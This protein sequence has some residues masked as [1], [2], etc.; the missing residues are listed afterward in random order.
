MEKKTVLSLFFIFVST[1]VLLFG[2]YSL[3]KSGFS[4]GSFENGI[5]DWLLPDDPFTAQSFLGSVAEVIC[6]ILAIAIT[7]VAIIVQLAANRYTSKIIDLFINNAVNVIILSSFVV[8]SVYGL[9]VTNS[10]EVTANGLPGENFFPR[11]GISAYL[12]LTSISFFVLVPYFF[13]VF[14][15]LKPQ[16]IINRIKRQADGFLKE[17]VIK[18]RKLGTEKSND[19]LQDN[20]NTLQDNVIANI[21]QLSEMAMSSLTQADRSLGVDC[22]K[23]MQEILTGESDHTEG[24]DLKEGYLDRKKQF[25][26][27]W[28]EVQRK[29]FGEFDQETINEL[30]LLRYWVE[31][32]IAQEFLAILIHSLNKERKLV[33]TI[34]ISTREIGEKALRLRSGSD[35]AVLHLTINSFNTYLKHGIDKDDILS[36]IDIL[37]QY[38]FFAEKILQESE[39]PNIVIVIANRFKDYGRIAFVE[40]MAPVLETIAFDLRSLNEV[41]FKCYR[42]KNEADEYKNIIRKLLDIFLAVDD[43]PERSQDEETLVGV[44]KSQAILASFYMLR[45]HDTFCSELLTKIRNDMKEEPLDRLRSIKKEILACET[46]MQ[47][48]IDENRPNREYITLNRKDALIEFFEQLGIDP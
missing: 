24:H 29:H 5:W 21:E 12:V 10:I 35:D 4:S 13:Y 46:E 41:A 33:N 26:K 20:V 40:H 9:W 17:A 34:A 30:V 42:A 25:P 7:V 3:D 45:K 6:G 23:S 39:D 18:N 31:M 36:T 22:I 38:R 15:F 2:S 11:I 27:E 1:L 32:K 16:N 14:Y 48:V 37:Y 19:L 44:R 47:P 8:T 43:F 28:L